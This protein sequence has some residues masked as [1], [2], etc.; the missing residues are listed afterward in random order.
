MEHLRVN[1]ITQTVLEPWFVDLQR[2]IQKHNILAADFYNVNETGIALGVNR[3]VNVID[4]SF[5][6]RTIIKPPEDREW[7]SIIKTI[8]ASSRI[9]RPLIIFKGKSL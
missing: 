8:S 9:L 2:L 1:T 7:V 4:L 3:N 6:D 5:T